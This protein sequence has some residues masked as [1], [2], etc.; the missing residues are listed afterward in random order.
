MIDWVNMKVTIGDKILKAMS[1][2]TINVGT[3]EGKSDGSK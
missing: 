1:E 2:F 3:E